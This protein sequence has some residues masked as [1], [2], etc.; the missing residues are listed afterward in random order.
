M[1]I[2]IRIRALRERIGITQEELARRIGVTPS[3]VG[4][5]ERDISHPKEEVLYR[6]FTALSCEPNE[7]FADYYNVRLSPVRLHMMK[8]QELDEHGRELVDACT[9]IEH[10]R[11]CKGL[12]AV[13]AR[14]FGKNKAPE[15]LRLSKRKG[16]GSILDKPDYKEE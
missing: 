7:L 4:N 16:A 8:Y 15:K 12:T 10:S 13:A 11:C 9:E 3:A 5:Y 2:G 14:S 6:L 1:G